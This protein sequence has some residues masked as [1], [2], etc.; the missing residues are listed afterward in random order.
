MLEKRRARRQD[1]KAK[2]M[3]E[4]KQIIE[5]EV[6]CLENG[7]DCDYNDK[8]CSNDLPHP[9]VKD[10][11]IVDGLSAL[12]AWSSKLQREEAHQINE[13]KKTNEKNQ[14]PFTE[15]EL[16]KLHNKGI[17]FVNGRFSCS[18]CK[19]ELKKGNLNSHLRGKR[20]ARAVNPNAEN[21]STET[22]RKSI[23][24]N[25][26]DPLDKKRVDFKNGKYF[27]SICQIK[28]DEGSLDSHLQGKRHNANKKQPERAKRRVENKK[29]LVSKIEISSREFIVMKEIKNGR[30]KQICSLCNVGGS[31][32]NDIK[33]HLIGRK[34][35][36][37]Y[38]KFGK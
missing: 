16:K 1:E 36:L 7:K 11:I 17:D 38:E 4:Y 23:T 13:S 8:P 28:F 32:E 37:N 21:E 3:N 14:I 30:M 27:C 25:I 15:K 10:E 9:T 5:P 29:N 34:H 6:I 35:K 22:A 2:K 31:G 20:H 33:S 12:D 18:V 19:I 26:S 24:I